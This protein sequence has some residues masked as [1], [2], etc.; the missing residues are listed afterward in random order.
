LV[1]PLQVAMDNGAKRVLIPIENKRNFLDVSGDVLE[2]IDPIF[3][4]DLR[5]AGFKA[6]GL[7]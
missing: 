4:G 2:N 1:E 7:N 5:T 3:Y 6:L